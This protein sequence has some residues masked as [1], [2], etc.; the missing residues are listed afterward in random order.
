MKKRTSKPYWE[1]DAG[2][3]ATATKEFDREFVLDTFGPPP[4]SA[5]SEWIKA[6]RKQGNGRKS[7]NHQTIRVNIDPDLLTRAESF[8]RRSRGAFRHSPCSSGS[9]RGND[10]I[11]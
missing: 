2:E 1:M 3:L 10:Q 9:W 5:R 4:P 8:A 7:A 11:N 6:S